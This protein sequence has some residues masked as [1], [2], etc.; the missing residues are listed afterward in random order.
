MNKI[1]NINDV[2]QSFSGNV[3]IKIKQGKRILKKVN[4]HNE[5]TLNLLYEMLLSLS[6]NLDPNKLPSYLGIGTGKYSGNKA[7]IL[8]GL[9]SEVTITRVHINTD[10]KG[11]PVTSD[12]GYATVVYQGILPYSV[13]GNPN[14]LTEI[15][16]F[17][18][19]SG[20]SLLA[21][22]EIDPISV[23]YGQALVV[24]WTFKIENA[25]K[26]N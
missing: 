9:I 18:T 14:N 6:G 8:E 2:T 15:G 11:N 5:A 12:E 7:Y 23:T 26:Q 1:G 25:T 19:L 24:E 3:T 21:R 16:L 20:N 4:V 13:L 22:V 17:G 10:Y